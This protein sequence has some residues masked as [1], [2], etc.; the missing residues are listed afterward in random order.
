[1]THS[2]LSNKYKASLIPSHIYTCI[3]LAASCD[4]HIFV[5]ILE[6]HQL[7]SKCN[8]NLSNRTTCNVQPSI[9]AGWTSHFY[10]Y[11]FRKVS[12]LGRSGGISLTIFRRPIV[13]LFINQYFQCKWVDD[14]DTCLTAIGFTYVKVCWSTRHFYFCVLS[15]LDGGQTNHGCMEFCGSRFSRKTS[16]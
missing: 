12:L 1:M 8:C 14:D 6:A 5:V 16:S 2:L 9:T 4:N 3:G 15:T 7:S 11:G 10:D 13:S